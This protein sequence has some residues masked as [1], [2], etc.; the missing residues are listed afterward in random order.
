M[1]DL[2]GAE[3]QP[4]SVYQDVICASSKFFKAA[5]S[6][7]WVE[8][9]E[10]KVSLPEVKPKHFQQYV[11]WLYSGNYQLQASQTDTAIAIG[12]AI[13]TGLEL[14]IL[15]DVLD[16][17]RFRNKMMENLAN[18]DLR[19]F[20]HPATLCVL[21]ERTPPTSLMRKMY[22]ERLIMRADRKVV[23]ALVKEYPTE[24]IQQVVVESLLRIGV[25][26]PEMFDAKVESFLE[27][28]SEDD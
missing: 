16:D 4:F 18:S 28:V 17:I 21:W 27:P 25:S 24:L 23:T 3:G 11:A 7:R 12:A 26:T 6:E 22:V 14:Y 10:K 8:G 19:Y 9:K 2:V 1:I 13:E 5:C 20:P 15:G